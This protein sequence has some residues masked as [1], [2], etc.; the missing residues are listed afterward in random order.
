[1]LLHWAKIWVCWNFDQFLLQHAF[2]HVWK[3]K[4]SKEIKNIFPHLRCQRVA[5]P[6]WR[7]RFPLAPPC[8]EKN[9]LCFVFIFSYKFSRAELWCCCCCCCLIY[10][11]WCRVSSTLHFVKITRRHTPFLPLLKGFLKLCYIQEIN[12]SKNVETKNGR[13]IIIHKCTCARKHHELS[14]NKDWTKR[15]EIF[16]GK[17]LFQTPPPWEMAHVAILCDHL[18]GKLSLLCN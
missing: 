13:K 6:T 12:V 8:V 5:I 17:V 1:M 4:K 3:W 10:L 11:R 14:I 2:T 7:V 16:C 18:A 15:K 9:L